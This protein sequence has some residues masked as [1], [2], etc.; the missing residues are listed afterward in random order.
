MH[1]RLSIACAVHDRAI[2]ERYLLPS[3]DALEGD[4]SRILLDNEGNVL[5]RNLARLFN[6][7]RRIDGPPARAFV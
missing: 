6:L 1:D 5:G 3:L 4:V 2:A 7:L